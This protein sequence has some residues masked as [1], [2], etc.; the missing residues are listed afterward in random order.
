MSEHGSQAGRNSGRLATRI[1]AIVILVFAGIVFYDAISISEEGGLGPQQPGFF[2]MIVGVGLL[3]FGVSFLL[4]TTLIP[5]RV[6]RTHVA[7]SLAE[8]HW[9]T[10]GL[11]ALSLLVYVFV[12]GFLGYVVATAI[13]FVAVAR[14]AGSRKLLRD[15]AIGIVLSV[16]I[17]FGFTEFLGVRLPAGVLEGIL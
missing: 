8:T 7:G 2:P 16:A 17:Y 3:V 14:I 6:Q 4:R 9:V 12:L 5:D 15:V 1:A 10:F 11:A 13:F